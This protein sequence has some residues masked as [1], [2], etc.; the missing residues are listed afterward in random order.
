MELSSIR[1]SIPLSFPR[2]IIVDI[3]KPSVLGYRDN[4]HYR[5]MMS[6][7]KEIIASKAPLGSGFKASTPNQLLTKCGPVTFD[8]GQYNII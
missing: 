4:G 5:P 7:T 6:D 1:Y 2:S 8:V 3:C